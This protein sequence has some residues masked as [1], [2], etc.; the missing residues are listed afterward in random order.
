MTRR[1]VSVTFALAAALV[2]TGVPVHGDAQKAAGASTPAAGTG[3]IKG[4]V[5]LMGPAPANPPIRMGAD[6]LCARLARQ[7][8]KRPIQEFVVTDGKGGLANAFVELQGTFT[9]VPPAPKDPVI[10][11]QQGCVY[12]PRVVGIRVGQALRMVNGDTLLHN[13]HGVSAKNNGFNHTQPQSGSV[14]N[15]VMKSPETMMHVTCDVHSWM[16]AWVGVESHPYFA[17]S[18]ADGSF[19]IANVPAGR[20]TIRAWQ[21]RYG[22]ITHTIDVK[23]GTTTTVELSYTGKEKPATRAGSVM[24]PEDTLAFFSRQE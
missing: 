23:P 18:G 21:E 2:A 4:L 22:W 6:P 12:T 13:L 16:S 8:G 11:R 3:T 24:I 5:K 1:I 9:N 19:T 20:R 17:V 10:I 14:D 7:S 15:F